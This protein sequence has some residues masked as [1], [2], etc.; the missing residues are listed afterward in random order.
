MKSAGD[1]LELACRRIADLDTPAYV[2]NSELR[3]IAV[4]EAYADFLGREIS[5]FIGRRSREL[6][7]RPEEEDREDKERRALVFGTE[8]NAVC[9]DAAGVGHER[10]QI[11]S[12]SPS[13]ERIYVLGIFED[14]ERRAVA[15]RK[16]AGSSQ[17]VN[18]SGT[19]ADLAQVREALENLAHP[20]GIIAADGR[21]LV[22][23]AAYRNG[24]TPVAAGESAWGESVNELDVLRTVLEDLP[25]AVFV[26]DD[27]HRLVYANKY[28]ETFSG[29]ARSEYLGMTE[30]EMFG[31]EGAEAIYQENLLALRDGISVELESEMPS[32]S[33]HV[34]PVI[35]R[36]NRVMTAD[37]RTYVVGSFSDIS[38]LKEREKALIESRKQQEILHR[39]IESILRSLP[40]GVLI[41]DNDHQILYVN[42]EFYSI[43]ELPLDDRF[44]GRPFIDVIR[45]NDELGRYDGTQ[46]PEEIY[47]FRKH[48]FEAEEPEPIELGWAGGKSVIFDSRRISNDRILLTYADISAVRER[49]KEIHETRAALERLGEMMRDATHAMSQGIAIVQDGIIKMSNEAMADILQIPPH[50]IEAGQGWLGMFE[51]CAARGD[52]H[53]AAEQI[54]QEWRANIAA[55]QPISTAFHV[56]GERWVNMDAT[57]SRGQHW[58]AL[59]TD[60]TELKSRE[61]ELRQL[62]SRAE[63]A[64]RAKS[65]FLAN[66]SHEIRTPMNGVLG[67]AELL[68]KTNLDARQKTFIDIIVKSGNALLTIINDILDF[69]KIDAGQMKLRKAAFDITEAVEDVATLLSSHAAEKNIELLVRAAPDLPAAVIGD[70]G[71]FRQIVTNLVGNAVKFTERGHVFVDVGFETIAGG[72]IMAIIRIEDTGIGIPREKLET[73]FDKFSQVDTSSTRRHEGTGL[74]LAITAGLVDLFGGYINVESEWGK[75]SVFTINLP[76]A[77]AAARLEPKPLPIN[78]QGARI[79]VVDDNEVNRRIL[80]E[81]LSLWGFDGV[82]AEGGGTG[83]AILKAAVDL[84]VTVDAVVLDYHMPDMNGADVARRL[85]ADPRFVELPIIF[86]TS[87]DISGTEKEFAALNG[88][89]HLMKP[90][91]ANVLRNT[92]VEVV[93]ARRVK[94]ASEAEIARLRVEAA[95]PAPAPAL[96]PQKRTAEFVDVLVAEDNEVN[97]IVF[98]QILQSTG[99]SFLVVNNGQEAVTAWESHTPRIIMMDVSMPVMNGHEATRTIREREKGQGHRVPIIGVTAHALESDRE[100]CLDAGM[101]DY[102]SKP[103]SPELLEEKIRQWLGKDELQPERTS[104]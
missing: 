11:E 59:F 27:K 38:P 1:I 58:V 34:Y 10:I 42:D 86:L 67:M 4:N 64:D 57:V 44:D 53:D 98:T 85:R 39:D 41:L 87:M 82:A 72:E 62:L 99:L 83:L 48:L 81:Q 89:A 69:S 75:G 7:D 92:V 43:W 55:R 102:M 15:G 20:I 16:A 80:T 63:A 25:V 96:V 9:F 37:G 103:I 78:V 18:D 47:A 3:Y 91:R 5:D 94:Q 54:L 6:F 90:A 33:G 84:G 66:M 88:H 71:R 60:V 95:V 73:V 40:I 14:R 74:G 52:F 26:R 65:E 32:N 24:A 61:E 68:A 17:A 30:H 13:P 2:K 45:R 19:A 12:F 77:V 8:E 35:S 21:P 104:Y 22:V 56:G 29:R 28:Y 46:T 70:A 100:A 31:P 50:Y 49:E 23:N 51:F 101:D 76:L 93:R 79:L 36:V 97:Q